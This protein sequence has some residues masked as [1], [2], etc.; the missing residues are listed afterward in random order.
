MP[1]DLVDQE[2]FTDTIHLGQYWNSLVRR[3]WL[4]LILTI[5]GL[6]AGLVY[7]YIRP[8]APFPYVAVI[9]VGTTAQGEPLEPMMTVFAKVKDGYLPKILAENQSTMADKRY[10]I[11]VEV[12]SQST[13]ITLSSA[14]SLE[15]E[16]NIVALLQQ[17]SD[18][19]LTDHDSQLTLLR[20]QL[21]NQKSFAQAE[22]VSSK[23]RAAIIEK[24]FKLLDE[25]STLLQ[26]QIKDKTAYITKAKENRL[27]V[28]QSEANRSPDNESLATAALLLDNDIQKEQTALA[29]LEE[30]LQVTL[31][32]DRGVLEGE[33]LTNQQDQAQ[34]QL[35]VDNLTLQIDNL[36]KSTLTVVPTRLL[37]MPVQSRRQ[38][39]EF[40]LIGGLGA[41]VFCALF[42]DFVERSKR[43]QV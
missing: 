39:L 23:A 40:G 9:E 30:R 27:T 28:I 32:E 36:K 24:K 33:L 10:T 20:E 7:S 43:Y 25:T 4:I 34:K 5:F 18:A 38:L 13:L 12:P 15:D 2:V 1:H 14:G 16:T 21:V 26:R 22:L 6:L 35:A 42:A 31:K 29:N 8:T 11:K 19:L 17:T 3:R 37:Q 41:G